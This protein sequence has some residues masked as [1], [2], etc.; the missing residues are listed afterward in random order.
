MLKWAGIFFA[1]MIA[2]AVIGFFVDVAGG[3][4]KILFVVCL[5]GFAA[6]FAMRW[7]GHRAN[8]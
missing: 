5:I 8:R 4:A 1:L 2:A 7:M 3:I 6:T